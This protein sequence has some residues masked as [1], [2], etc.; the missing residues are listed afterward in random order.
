MKV[1]INH[2]KSNINHTK[3]FI[4]FTTI[5]NLPKVFNTNAHTDI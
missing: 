4:Y 1:Q 5:T 3:I 2:L